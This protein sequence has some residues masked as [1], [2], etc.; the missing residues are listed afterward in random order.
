[1]RVL[2]RTRKSTLSSSCATCT[3]R[4]SCCV[5]TPSACPATR[6]CERPCARFRCDACTLHR[7]DVPATH[8]Y[9]VNVRWYW[10]WHYYR[11]SKRK[12][13]EILRLIRSLCRCLRSPSRRNHAPTRHSK[14]CLHPRTAS[15]HVGIGTSAASCPGPPCGCNYVVLLLACVAQRRFAAG[16]CPGYVSGLSSA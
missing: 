3:L 14:P 11:S 8:P 16:L 7:D 5:R 15:A 10:H 6:L 9:D 12:L 13:A 1:M 2:R 4:R